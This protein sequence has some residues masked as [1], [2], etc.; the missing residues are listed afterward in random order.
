MKKIK[1]V[2]KKI[3]SKS[4]TL[5][6]IARRLPYSMKLFKMFKGVHPRTCN[7]CGFNGLFTA[8][9]TPPRFDA[10]C[11]SCRSL[12]RHRWFVLADQQHNFLDNVKSVLHFAPEE[13][14]AQYLRKKVSL[15]SSADIAQA[16]VDYKENIESLSF[17]DCSF[18][19]IFCSHVLE[20]VDDQK[21]LRELYRVLKPDGLLICMVP[22]DYSLQQ[23]YENDA[24][25]D[26]A[27]RFIH[28]GQ[29]DH[30]RLYGQD[31]P[32]RLK[33]AGFSVEECRPTPELALK[34]GLLF[35]DVLYLARREKA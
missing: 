34:H 18:E 6:S 20:H 7:C 9:G 16:G 1:R 27:G 22:V 3:L 11:P 14:I 29:H 10:L 25:I 24:I 4:P 35:K 32:L 5:L 17:A 21:A 30:V 26:N 8:Y 28:F 12:E 13:I 2:I 15:Y 19:G 23:T 33:N 31:F